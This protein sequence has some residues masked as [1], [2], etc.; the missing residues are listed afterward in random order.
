MRFFHWVLILLFL[1]LVSAAPRQMGPDPDS[2]NRAASDTARI[3]QADR[4]QELARKCKNADPGQALQYARRAHRL[5]QE[6]PDDTLQ[7]KVFG[8]ISRVFQIMGQ[9][10]SALYY[11]RRF[12]DQAEAAGHTY[13]LANAFN[14]EGIVQVKRGHYPEAIASIQRYI[15][16]IR[17]LDEPRHVAMGYN[18]LGS[19]YLEVG[20][21]DQALEYFMKSLQINEEHSFKREG[22]PKA[23]TNIALIYKKIDSLDRALHHLSRAEEVFRE[24]DDQVGLSQL[25]INMG[26]VYKKKGALERARKCYRRSMELSQSLGRQE[27]IAQVCVCLADIESKKGSDQQVRQLYK[28][29][30]ALYRDIEDKEGIANVLYHWGRY[31]NRN[32]EVRSSLSHLTRALEQAGEIGAVDLLRE[33]CYELYKVH[34]K[35]GHQGKALAYYKRYDR[36]QDS[37]Y[38]RT[39]SNH[40]AKWQIRYQTQQKEKR[41]SLL[42]T[43]GELN[44]SRIKRQRL[45]LIVFIAGAIVI[46][47]FLFLLYRLY[48]SKQKINQQLSRQNEDIRAKNQEIAAQSARLSQ[49]NE[50]LQQANATKDKFLSIISHDLKNPF[51]SIL[52]LSDLLVRK[53]DQLDP[54]KVRKFHHS[55]YITSRHAYDLLSNLLQ[56]SRSQLQRIEIHRQSFDMYELVSENIM[57]QQERA[58]M[59]EIRL[60]NK[61]DP[62][63]FVYADHN[64]I[65]TVM[66]N[67]LSNAIKFTRAGGRV[68][69]GY[70]EQGEHWAFHVKDNGK[71]IPPEN[72]QKLFHPEYVY[73][74]EG[75]DQEK[76][77]GLG[78]LLCK[79]F[80]NKNG[81]T[82]YVS[83]T[84]EEGSTFTFTLPRPQPDPAS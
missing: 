80:V 59:K 42:E 81:G 72:R 7:A 48:R 34:E 12:K 82:I 56:W 62:Y 23:L 83:S 49:T 55:I 2:L 41:I 58:R 19:C 52:G 10:D 5:L 46:L 25:Y 35:Q 3:N 66:R 15:E 57:M 31:E 75:T 77:T 14:Y 45:V 78:L 9:L 8:R 29:A 6:N 69:I 38:S 17:Q 61:M 21:Y 54:Q 1:L 40:I 44:Q 73:S 18:N 43:Q 32:G 26:S 22:I 37:L 79:E 68:E 16:L 30:L 36:Y 27:G 60:V 39:S 47:G 13:L 71:G 74:E 53:G 4:L 33:C 67:L 64:M 76:G 84:P 20:D 11:A 51:N 24:V 65:T 63:L 70:S 50:E 28:K